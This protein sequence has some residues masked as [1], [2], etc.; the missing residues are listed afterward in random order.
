VVQAEHV[1]GLAL[2]EPVP[3]FDIVSAYRVEG[4]KIVK[5]IGLH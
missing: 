3:T 4:G 2:G 1:T 5:C